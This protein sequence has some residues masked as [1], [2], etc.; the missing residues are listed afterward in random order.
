MTPF[1]VDPA[2]EN[3][4]IDQDGTLMGAVRMLPIKDGAI[5]PTVEELQ[6]APIFGYAR[7]DAITYADDDWEVLP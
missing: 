6:D 5:P 4:A 1:I 2:N 3:M 7:P